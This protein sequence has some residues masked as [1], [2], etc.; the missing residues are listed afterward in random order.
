MHIFYLVALFWISMNY[1]TRLRLIPLRNKKIAIR[2]Y[3]RSVWT[4]VHRF[5]AHLIWT[6]KLGKSEKKNFVKLNIDIS[7]KYVSFQ[8][9]KEVYNSYMKCLIH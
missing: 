3:F 4:A 1:T 5:W 8:Y 2:E 9:T 7:C 6:P